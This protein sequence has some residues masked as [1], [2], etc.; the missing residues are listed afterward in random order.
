MAN[1]PSSPVPQ[2]IYT[3]GV[4]FKTLISPF[5]N[6]A[7][8][9]RPKWGQGKVTFSLMYNAI[10]DAE[11]TTLWDFYVARKGSNESFTFTDPLTS[12]NYTMR[13]SDD[14]MSAD[15]FA[16]KVLKTGLNLIQVP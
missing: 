6:G 13:F 1:Y 2:W 12:T 10:T 5:E 3:K 15:E 16:Y 9:R 14:N 7:E 11:F 8:Q 4:Q